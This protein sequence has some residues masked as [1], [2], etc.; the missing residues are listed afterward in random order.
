MPYF[1]SPICIVIE[2]SSWHI[3]DWGEKVGHKE[4][5]E[6]ESSKKMLIKI[7]A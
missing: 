5:E 4:Y 6:R 2:R 3:V 7:V 1:K